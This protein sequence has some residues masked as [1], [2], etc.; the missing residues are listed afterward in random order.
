M[1]T[2]YVLLYTTGPWQGRQ[3]NYTS[4]GKKYKHYI[5]K[6]LKFKKLNIINSLSQ[7]HQ[8]A[9]RTRKKAMHMRKADM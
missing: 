8:Q 1:Q 5:L 2:N 6:H 3:K 7:G 4:D 9:D